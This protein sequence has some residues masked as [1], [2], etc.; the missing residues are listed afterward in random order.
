Q[1][2]ETA[3]RR[4]VEQRQTLGRVQDALRTGTSEAPDRG[5]RAE[6]ED[7]I[8]G[9]LLDRT[10]GPIARRRYAGRVEFVELIDRHE[11]VEPRPGCGD[12]RLP[13]RQS[14]ADDGHQDTDEKDERA[15]SPA[16]DPEES[17]RPED[18]DEAQEGEGEAGVDEKDRD[19]EWIFS[20]RSS[21]ATNC[22][23]R[24]ARVSGFL[25]L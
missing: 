24:L 13:R 17:Q 12:P 18:R 9:D 6:Q 21:M 20:C 14:H 23:M 4:H 1:P 10:V 8:G 7:L 19:H 2:Q 3:T 25:A 16:A 22:W 5:Q 15:A 11:L